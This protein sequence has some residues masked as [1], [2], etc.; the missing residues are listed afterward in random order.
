MRKNHSISLKYYSSL[1]CRIFVL[2]ASS[3]GECIYFEIYDQNEIIYSCITDSF[4]VNQINVP[5]SFAKEHSI[6]N[7][8]DVFWSHPHDDHSLGLLEII[9]EFKPEN[10][11]V[12]ADLIELPAV[13]TTGSSQVLKGVNEL[14][15]YDARRK[16]NCNVTEVSTNTI[17]LEENLHVNDKIIPLAITA[18][19]P[20]SGKTR[21]NVINADYNHLND[22][23]ISISVVVGDF[24]FMLTGDLQD[25]IV[26]FIK[27]EYQ[28]DL[29]TPNLLKVPHHGSKDSLA[30]LNLFE[31]GF[32]IDVSVCTVKKS[33]GLPRKESIEVYSQNSTRLYLVDDNSFG[34]AVWGMEIDIL[35]ASMK[36]IEV[37][38]FNCICSS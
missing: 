21:K 11:Y 22:Y 15:G 19:A 35:N 36:E 6:T 20:V 5:L 23:S 1:K 27:E 7:V 12:P 30:L 37:Q 32:D 18:F 25:R 29:A 28:R 31:D 13:I 2:G 16:Y 8:K 26:R 4:L 33:S 34:S 17:I 24:S 38:S 14:K 9:E 10:V 3:E